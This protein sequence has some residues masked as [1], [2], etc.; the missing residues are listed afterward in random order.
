VQKFDTP[1]EQAT[2]PSLEALQAFSLLF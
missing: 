1:P 2:T